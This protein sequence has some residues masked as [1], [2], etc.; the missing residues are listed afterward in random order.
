[1]LAR[2]SAQLRPVI[3]SANR[4]DLARFMSSTANGANPADQLVLVDRQGPV[5]VL[6]LNRPKALNALSS[7]LF[8]QLNNELDKA[9]QDDQVKCIVLTGGEKVFAAGAD[10][11]EMKDKNF[12]E[13]YR[14]NFLGSW[15]RVTS[16]R[17]PI[18]GAVSG[19]A[20]GGGCELAMM[21]DILLASPTAIFGQP[22]ITLGII[23]GAGGTQRLTKIVGKPIAMDMVLT[24]RKI[25]AKEAE[26]M[27]LV[28]RVVWE[29]GKSVVQEA[30]ALAKKIGGFG[31]VAVQ[32]GKEAVDAAN[33]LPL[34]EGLRLER[35]LFQ[36]LFATADQK[37]GMA[38]F[39]EKRKPAFKDE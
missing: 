22:E 2:S 12:A 36:Q 34:S 24:G 21:C 11:K 28:S 35:R 3:T 37:E 30:V 20:L 32:A 17:K 18:V 25:D 38:A 10:I 16:F 4:L 7:P 29:E 19:Y 5:T 39:A 23:P 14:S 13:V 6:T 31:A 33:E 27:G 8:V 26:R 15:A 9:A 1:M